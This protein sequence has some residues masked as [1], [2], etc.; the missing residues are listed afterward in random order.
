MTILQKV[1]EAAKLRGDKTLAGTRDAFALCSEF[2]WKEDFTGES[3]TVSFYGEKFVYLV[4]DYDGSH[5][6]EMISRVIPDC[7]DFTKEVS[8]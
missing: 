3:L 8:E 1:F 6:L 7:Y 4:G 2:D 5:T